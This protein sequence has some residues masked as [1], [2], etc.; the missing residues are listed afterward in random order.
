MTAKELVDIDVGLILL[1]Y[2]R[3]AVIKALAHQVCVSEES[4]AGEIERLRIAK[5]VSN[6]RKKKLGSK[7]NL[8]SILL[9]MDDK[10]DCL[11]RLSERFDNKTFLPELKDLR[12]FL[13]RHGSSASSVKSRASAQM[14]LFRVLA[15]FSKEELEKIFSEVPERSR[16][17]SLGLISDEILGRRKQSVSQRNNVPKE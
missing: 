7:F 9:G 1:R 8:D 4:L 15:S 12:R 13:E 16:V 6:S 14:K 17:S 11:K 3:A 10:A 2:G 5:E